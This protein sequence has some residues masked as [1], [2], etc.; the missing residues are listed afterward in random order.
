MKYNAFKYL[1]DLKE[2]GFPAK[3]AEVMAKGL[4]EFTESQLATKR[5][6]KDIDL[7]IELA[8]KD[9][10]IWMGGIAVGGIGLLIALGKLGLLIPTS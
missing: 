3:Q 2:A 9:L 7:K 1:D 4:T 8:K 5:D 10:K 6:I